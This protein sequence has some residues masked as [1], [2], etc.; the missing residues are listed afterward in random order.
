MNG[1]EIRRYMI[2]DRNT[3]SEDNRKRTDQELEWEEISREHSS[4]NDIDMTLILD[5]CLLEIY[6]DD[7]LETASVCLF[8]KKPYT[9]VK[10][11]G[12]LSISAVTL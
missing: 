5:G 8:P 3:K 6:A 1:E 2:S 12:G 11:E 7:G 4:E 10:A 9:T